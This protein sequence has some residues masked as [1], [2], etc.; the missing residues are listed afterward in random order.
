MCMCARRFVCAYERQ[1]AGRE[2]ERERERR[3]RRER[4]EKVQDCER[5]VYHYRKRRQSI[6]TLHSIQNSSLDK[7]GALNKLSIQ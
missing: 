1:R 7:I 3:E 4:R 2:I 5:V 6:H